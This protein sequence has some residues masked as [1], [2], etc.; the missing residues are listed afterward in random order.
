MSLTSLRLQK[1]I[2]LR[3]S[4][5]ILL[6]IFTDFSDS[7]LSFFLKIVGFFA[8]ILGDLLSNSDDGGRVGIKRLITRNQFVDNTTRG[9]ESLPLR[10]I[11]RTPIAVSFLFGT[12]GE[13][14]HH[15]TQSQGSHAPLGGRQARLSGVEREYL[16]QR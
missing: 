14:S 16:H 11:K 9:F 15:A 7:F 4:D 12:T 2:I 6:L 13:D 3:F 10:Q 5:I 8:I 1:L